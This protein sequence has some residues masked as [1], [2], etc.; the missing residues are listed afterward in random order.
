MGEG[1]CPAGPVAAGA[2]TGQ[3][4]DMRRDWG[5]AG[6][7]AWAEE[8]Q[9]YRPS[10]EWVPSTRGLATKGCVRHTVG[11]TLL[12][13]LPVEKAMLG[14]CVEHSRQGRDVGGLSW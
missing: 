3:G 1:L 10:A 8:Q 2:G 9:G 14:G 7:S 4:Q 13:R 12:S 5:D 11:T 6:R